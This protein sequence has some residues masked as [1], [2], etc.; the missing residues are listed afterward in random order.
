MAAGQIA[1]QKCRVIFQKGQKF[2]G[3]ENGIGMPL[4]LS[5]NNLVN[6]TCITDRL[7]LDTEMSHRISHFMVQLTQ[8]HFRPWQLGL[9]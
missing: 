2:R 8:V 7:D 3:A 6:K 9:V 5:E 4:D 1:E